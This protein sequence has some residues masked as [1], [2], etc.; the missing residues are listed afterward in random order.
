VASS[1]VPMT[2][3][4]RRGQRAMTK[5]LSLFYRRLRETVGRVERLT[6]QVQSYRDRVSELEDELR[7][8][9]EHVARLESRFWSEPRPGLTVDEATTVIDRS[10]ADALERLGDETATAQPVTIGEQTIVFRDNTQD[11]VHGHDRNQRP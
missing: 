5:F 8:V 11:V 7:Q 2:K 1:N 3:A 10:Y 6:V 9:A 4:E